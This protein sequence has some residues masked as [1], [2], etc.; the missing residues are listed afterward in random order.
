MQRRK[1]RELTTDRA[2]QWAL[3]WWMNRAP[4]AA[5]GGP[6]SMGGQWP[7]RCGA[8]FEETSADGRARPRPGCLN[9]ISC[10]FGNVSW[11]VDATTP[12]FP[13][14][15]GRIS[16]GDRGDTARAGPSGSPFH[17]PT[18]L[19]DGLGAGRSPWTRLPAPVRPVRRERA[20]RKIWVPRAVAKEVAA[21]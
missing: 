19:A 5:R 11:R 13:A 10:R 1:R 16:R 6:M 14:K 20:R 21:A 15:C 17:W 8:E 7:L 3:L 4:T 18:R 2:A 9:G 12:V